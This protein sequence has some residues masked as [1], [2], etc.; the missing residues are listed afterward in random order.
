MNVLFPGLPLL[1]QLLLFIVFL[2]VVVV[3]A[4]TTVLFVLS[5]SAL[6]R[7][8]APDPDSADTFLWVFLVPALDEALT[9]NDSVQ[10]LFAV[11]ARNKAIFVIDDGSTDATA[12]V[13]ATIES[14]ELEVIRRTPPDARQ[15][16]AAALNAAWRRLDA[17][18]SSGRW[19][20]WPRDRVIVCVVDA[21][22]RL[23]PRAPLVIAPHFTAERIGGLQLL[24]RIYNRSRILAWLQ[25]VEFSIYG[26]LYQAGRTPYGAAGMGGNGQFNRLSALD[27][28]ADPEV[29]GPGETG[30]PRTRT[31]ATSA[32]DRLAE[33]GGSEGQR[34]AA[35]RAAA[36]P[37]AP[38]THALGAGKPAGDGASARHG[39]P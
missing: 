4:W 26:L 1:V 9:I 18:L 12:S 25:D 38:A 35:R 11:D 30:S 27:S 29:G 20:G 16:K 3:F 13:L 32:R 19:A 39:A 2:L 33:R 21:D 8:P 15:G 17:V 10:R 22:G 37:A 24:V 6:H 31:W 28:I 14:A 36:P 7:A 5:R 23:D 34:R